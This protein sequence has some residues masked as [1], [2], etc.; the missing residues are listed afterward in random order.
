MMDYNPTITL[1]QRRLKLLI[2]YDYSRYPRTT[3]SYY[4]MAA[5]RRD[6]IEVYRRGE[7]L[8]DDLD[9]VLNIEPVGE[10]VRIPGVPTHYYEIDNHVILGGEEWYYQDIDVL[11]LAHWD[12]AS[13][14]HGYPIKELPCAAD[15]NIHK[16]FP[17][18]LEMYDI[19]LIGN[20][21]YPKRARL[22]REMEKRYTVLPEM[23]LWGEDYS[24]QLSQCKILFNCAMNNDAN[25]RAFESIAIQKPLFTDRIPVLSRYLEEDEHYVGYDDWA[26]LHQKI[27]YYLARGCYRRSIARQGAEHVRTFHSYDNRLDV[28]LSTLT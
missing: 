19:G 25:M 23:K 16:P 17:R 13:F 18:E 11:W 1:P 9:L 27:E 8:P 24:R 4:E 26:E 21:T 3:A 14:Y 20:R 2:N 10:F 15:P 5:R 22:L 7:A 12:F 28:I 6:N